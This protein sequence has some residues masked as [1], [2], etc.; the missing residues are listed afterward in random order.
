[1]HVEDLDR[2]NEDAARTPILAGLADHWG[3]IDE[4]LNPDLVDLLGSYRAGRTVLV[5]GDDGVVVGTGTVMP[6]TAG[7]AEILRMSVASSARSD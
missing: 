6:R 3:P 4:T 1:M 2:D 7:V 5:R